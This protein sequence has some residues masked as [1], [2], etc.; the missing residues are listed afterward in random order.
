VARILSEHLNLR[1]VRVLPAC[2]DADDRLWRR[3]THEPD[4]FVQI[5]LRQVCP[6]RDVRVR[7][8]PPIAVLSTANKSE[9]KQREKRFHAEV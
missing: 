4:H 7:E 1:G 2:R 5:R 3:I 6:R 9:Q 8:V